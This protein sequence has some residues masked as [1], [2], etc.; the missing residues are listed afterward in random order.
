MRT[1]RSYR[2]MKSCVASADLVDQAADLRESRVR[3]SQNVDDSIALAGLNT[4]GAD[5][6][7][8]HVFTVAK[9]Q[10]RTKQ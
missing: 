9:H 3:T 4:H 5:C 1:E 10:L 6:G 7:K 8:V 2:A